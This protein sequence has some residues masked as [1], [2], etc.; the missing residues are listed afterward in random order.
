MTLCSA[1]PIEKYN[2]GMGDISN[3]IRPMIPTYRGCTVFIKKKNIILA[4]FFLG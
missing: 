3:F 2:G 1:Y 4:S